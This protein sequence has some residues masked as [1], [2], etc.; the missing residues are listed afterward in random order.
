MVH[1]LPGKATKVVPCTGDAAELPAA[2][3]LVKP[4]LASAWV[5]ACVRDANDNPT[6]E[7]TL[8][9]APRRTA[10]ARGGVLHSARAGTLP[11]AVPT[12]V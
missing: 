10:G 5:W 6:G 3:K 4:A 11:H 9:E 1:A 7:T 2:A 12:A 8:C